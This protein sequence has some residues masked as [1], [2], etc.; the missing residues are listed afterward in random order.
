MARSHLWLC[1]VG[2][3]RQLMWYRNAT[4]R[5]VGNDILVFLWGLRGLLT[6]LEQNASATLFRQSGSR[7]PFLRAKGP[8]RRLLCSLRD[9]DI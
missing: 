9:P 2:C 6:L 3:L 7:R 5:S 8:R 1:G 4:V